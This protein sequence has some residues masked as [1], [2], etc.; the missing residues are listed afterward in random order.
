MADF[1]FALLATLPRRPK[2]AAFL[3]LFYASTVFLNALQHVY[4]IFY[5]GAY[6]PGIVTAVLLLFP[7]T[8]GNAMPP[9][10]RRIH[11]ISIAI[12]KRL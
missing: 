3:I 7:V 2:F 4:W 11:E 1:A 6:S 10:I 5:F 8:A 12:A 9:Q